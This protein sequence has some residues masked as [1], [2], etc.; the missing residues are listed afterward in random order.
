MDPIIWAIVGGLA[1]VAIAAALY[2]LNRSWGNFPRDT[3]Y[4][5]PS[6]PS[7]PGMSAGQSAPPEPSSMWDAPISSP[8]APA[9]A[10]GWDALAHSV[11]PPLAA[12]LPDP[13]SW[14]VPIEHPLVRRAA[15]QALAKGGPMARYVVR[16][17]GQVAFDF[18]QISDPAERRQAYA[19]MRRFTEG[20]DVDFRAMMQLIQQLFRP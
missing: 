16:Q 11:A 2:A 8:P 10:S 18:G 4:R 12:D 7:A 1:I 9:Q 15:E 20:Q 14:V 3:H 13:A 5:P 6:G 17:G 19:L